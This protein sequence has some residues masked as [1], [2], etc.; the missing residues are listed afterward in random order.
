MYPEAA[1]GSWASG[2]YSQLGAWEIKA[3][4]SSSKASQFFPMG[5]PLGCP[6]DLLPEWSVL[7]SWSIDV[8]V[9]MHRTSKEEVFDPKVVSFLSGGAPQPDR[10]P[11]QLLPLLRNRAGMGGGVGVNNYPSQIDLTPLSQAVLTLGQA[12]AGGK[13]MLCILFMTDARLLGGGLL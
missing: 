4:Q 13:R 10:I 1:P 12:I 11:G 8:R 6:T 5:N 9:F 2:S 7:K 3:S